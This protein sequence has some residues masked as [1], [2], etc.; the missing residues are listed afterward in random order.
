VASVAACSGN[1]GKPTSTSVFAA[2]GASTSSGASAGGAFA[3]GGGDGGID[4]TN[5]VGVGA[6]GT[7]GGDA[8][9]YLIF[10]DTDTQLFTLDPTQPS[11]PITLVG[12]F[13]CIGPSGS[14]NQQSTAM[15]DLAV[16]RSQNLWGLSSYAV[17][18]LDVMGTTVHCEAE[19][20]VHVPDPNATDP[21]FP[22]IKF[23]AL[24]FAPEGVIKPNVEV[25]VAGDTAGQ[26]WAIDTST[27]PATITQH[28]AFG[29]V[30]ADD[31]HGHTYTYPGGLWELSGDIVFLANN[32]SP[33]G[34]ATV[35]DCPM[36]PDNSGCNETDTLIE[37]DMTALGQ[38]GTQS[39]TKS[40]RGQVIEGS[41]CGGNGSY[42]FG[43][44][45][46]IASWNSNIYGFA[47][48]GDLVQISN[49]D[50]TACLVKAYA[51]DLFSGAAVTTV[52]PVIPPPTM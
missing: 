15:T 30:P 50:G 3:N 24:T 25:L 43:S 19:I 34:F 9:S 20:Q 5:G 37:I 14:P 33:V 36:P 40:I 35:R 52:A 7:G 48:S 12:T 38:A 28:G 21:S 47:R 1:S 42:G 27:S 41:S 2:G 31:G 18:K 10:A 22:Y 11:I 45:F 29:T 8:G 51:A 4:F 49:V 32:G 6:S 23:E 39:V 13:D 17:R 44:L 46:G 26:L 16:D